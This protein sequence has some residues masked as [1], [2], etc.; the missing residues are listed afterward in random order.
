MKCNRSVFICFVF[1]FP[2]RASD[3]AYIS[4][5]DQRVLHFQKLFM[6]SR[7]QQQKKGNHLE[8]A[9]EGWWSRRSADEVYHW[10]ITL[11]KRKNT[12]AHKN[13]TESSMRSHWQ[14]WIV[15]DGWPPFWKEDNGGQDKNAKVD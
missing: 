4:L 8:K 3:Y 14:K 6:Q 1:L 11:L 12:H 15:F 10:L 2:P 7:Q 13:E 5:F 9:N